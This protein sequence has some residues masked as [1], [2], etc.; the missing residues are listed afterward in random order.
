MPPPPLDVGA[1]SARYAEIEREA[2]RGFAATTRTITELGRRDA[3]IAREQARALKRA[4]GEYFKTFARTL[5]YEIVV[6][7]THTGGITH[8][9]LFDLLA[10]RGWDYGAATRRLRDH[11]RVTLLSEFSDEPV[12][13]LAFEVESVA[14]GAIL[15]FVAARLDRRITDIDR[16]ALSPQYARAKR[17]RFG[18]GRAGSASGELADAV[19]E[20]GR[21]VLT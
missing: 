21:I 13:P 2:L 16:P 1:L 3:R 14:A 9:A 4:L 18:T 7:G 19:R 5:G 15:E 17:K 10:A 6:P 20:R 12:V 8:Q 11:V